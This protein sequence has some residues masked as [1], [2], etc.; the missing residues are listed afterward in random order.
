MPVQILIT[1]RNIL[2]LSFKLFFLFLTPQHCCLLCGYTV[3]FHSHGAGLHSERDATGT[4]QHKPCYVQ[5]CTVLT[6]S[7]PGWCFNSPRAG[8]RTI[9]AFFVGAVQST[10]TGIRCSAAVAVP[11]AR[12]PCLFPWSCSFVEVGRG[13][14]CKHT[15]FCAVITI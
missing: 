9:K 2:Y 14:C 8:G 3:P 5:C 1:K 6:A 12:T 11:E 13:A 15:G 10:L 4:H 7:G